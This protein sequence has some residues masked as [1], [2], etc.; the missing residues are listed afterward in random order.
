MYVCMYVE[1]FHKY[2]KKY[3]VISN[4]LF[5]LRSLLEDITRLQAQNDFKITVSRKNSG[6]IIAPKFYRAGLD[7]KE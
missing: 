1:Y 6:D 5:I 3:L 7:T 2:L 4:Y